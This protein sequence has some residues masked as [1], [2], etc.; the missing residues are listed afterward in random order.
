VELFPDDLR[1]IDEAASEID[2]QARVIRK[3]WKR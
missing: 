1:E 3:S 2:V